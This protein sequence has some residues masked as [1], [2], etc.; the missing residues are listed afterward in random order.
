MY[1]VRFLQEYLNF[2]FPCSTPNIIYYN[3]EF[4]KQKAFNHEKWQS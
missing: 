3:K 1:S 4:E 2:F